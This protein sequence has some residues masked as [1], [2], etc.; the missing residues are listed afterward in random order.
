MKGLLVYVLLI[1]GLLD[2]VVTY[3]YGKSNIIYGWDFC[4]YCLRVPIS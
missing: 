3:D 4:F 1:A 2:L